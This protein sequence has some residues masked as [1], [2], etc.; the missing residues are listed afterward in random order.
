MAGSI[1]G[2]KRALEAVADRQLCEFGRPGPDGGTRVPVTGA[3]ILGVLDAFEEQVARLEAERDEARRERDESVALLRDV[4]ESISYLTDDF[5]HHP[6]SFTPAEKETI[7][8]F[9]ARYDEPSDGGT[10]P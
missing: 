9:L 5:G 10:K 7:T 3:I 8:A 6:A 2:I 4:S 1:E